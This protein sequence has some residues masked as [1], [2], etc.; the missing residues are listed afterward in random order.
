[1]ARV[2]VY[3]HDLDRLLAEN[4][5]YQREAT[6]LKEENKLLRKAAQAD[7]MISNAVIAII[8]HFPSSKGWGY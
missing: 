6:Q 3:E 7:A 4:R 1:M 8:D 2:A 5:H